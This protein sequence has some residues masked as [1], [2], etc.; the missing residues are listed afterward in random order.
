MQR[1]ARALYKLCVA[2]R[3]TLASLLTTS[4]VLF[5][6]YAYFTGWVYTYYSFY[7]LGISSHSYDLSVNNYLASAFSAVW[8]SA[9]K[10]LLLL[11]LPL[12]A[13]ASIRILRASLLADALTA[14]VLIGLLV[15]LF[16]VARSAGIRYATA[17]R[18]GESG[19]F[20]RVTLRNANLR[21]LAQDFK[22]A[23][24]GGGLQL[25]LETPSSVYV[26]LQRRPEGAQYLPEGRLYE[27]RRSD[28]L[29]IESFVS[30][31]VALM[32]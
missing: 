26:L 25:V 15:A 32:P 10:S 21:G 28:I 8:Q 18:K 23:N 24:A 1:K 13:L 16:V 3:T 14:I 12:V 2:Q 11:P 7:T 19:V 20:V 30:A 4:T 6:A 9:P 22:E 17:V 29:T 31:T 27:L 5:G